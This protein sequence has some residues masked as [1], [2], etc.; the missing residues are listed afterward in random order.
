MIVLN[1]KD[2]LKVA[3]NALRLAPSLAGADYGTV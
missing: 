3:T 2:Y 1:N